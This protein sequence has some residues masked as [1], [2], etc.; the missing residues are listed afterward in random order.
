VQYQ[1]TYWTAAEAFPVRSDWGKLGLYETTY[2]GAKS[3]GLGTVIT[4]TL[5][6]FE[7]QFIA[8]LR[9][10]GFP[11]LGLVFMLWRLHRPPVPS[12][13]QDEERL[14]G[15]FWL[16]LGAFLVGYAVVFGLEL[17][18][19]KW[20]LTRFMVPACILCL[21]GLVLAV[22][23]PAGAVASKKRRLAWT[24]ILVGACFGPLL[25][26]SETFRRNWVRTAAVDP[27]PHR[28]NLLVHS[29]GPFVE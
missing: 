1:T 4:R 25:E 28:L 19:I 24:L 9:I 26:F 17:G 21:T 18:H 6:L 12:V 10:Y 16:A 27:L 8:S 20:F 29:Q 2:R 15:W 22:A 3:L 7:S 5:T 14:R 11:L 13:S 23:P